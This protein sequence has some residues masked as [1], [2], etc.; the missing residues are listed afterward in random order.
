[1]VE[2]IVVVPFLVIL[3]IGVMD[4]GRVF[5]TSVAVA[6][7]ARAGAEWGAWD[8]A[9]ATQTTNIENFAKLDGAETGG[10]TVTAQR[11]CRCAA[12]VVG[13]SS[14]CGGYGDA[15]V[16]VEVTASKSG[17]F[18]LKYPGIPSSIV[19]SRKATFRAK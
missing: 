9:R 2:L 15:R 19:V 12:T 11:V 5:F 3:A 4:F 16:F 13:C 6:N 8:Q 14:V 7:A 1:M 17:S 10:L 18:F